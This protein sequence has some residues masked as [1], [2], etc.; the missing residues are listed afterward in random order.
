M[1]NGGNTNT[2]NNNN[3]NGFINNFDIVP[4]STS[5]KN[6]LLKIEDMSLNEGK[7]AKELLNSTFTP[8]VSNAPQTTKN[9]SFNQK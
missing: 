5:A 9:L 3:H 2:N 6:T 1:S 7:A 8:N 4:S